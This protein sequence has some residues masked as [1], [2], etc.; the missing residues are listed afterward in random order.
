MSAPEPPVFTHPLNLLLIASAGVSAAWVGDWRPLAVGAAGELIWLAMRPLLVRRRRA[1]A[2]R[3]EVD[4]SEQ[5]RLRTLTEPLR[6][7]FLELDH[8]RDD[9]RR[10]VDANPSLEATGLERELGKVDALLRAW[11]ELAAH[12]SVTRAIVDETDL[13]ALEAE[14]R[15]AAGPEAAERQER[16]DAARR[17]RSRV[18]SAEAELD[19]VEAALRA[20]RDRVVS[21]SSTRDL[22]ASLDELLVGVGAAERAAAE[23][24]ALDRSG[25]AGARKAPGGRVP[26]S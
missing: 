12:V 2:A 26:A 11:L 13:D 10:L 16:L 15:S 14:V 21:L 9:V 25:L 23:L 1:A 7:R 22:G 3:M 24:A 8:V 6:R 17:A 19:R 4:A 5:T 18:E 20:L